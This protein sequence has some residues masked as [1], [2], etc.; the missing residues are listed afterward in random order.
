M[1]TPQSVS[2]PN[3]SAF[4]GALGQFESGGRYGLGPNSSGA[5]GAYQMTPGFLNTYAAGAGY[6]GATVS[7][8]Q[9]DPIAQDTIASYAATQ[10]YNNGVYPG[11]TFPNATGSWAQVANGWLTGSP[12]IN[13]FI[14]NPIFCLTA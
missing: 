2:D 11:G 5:A 14:S 9:S 10:M 7:S 3:L 6:P 12:T 13:L 8:I 4:L 1:F